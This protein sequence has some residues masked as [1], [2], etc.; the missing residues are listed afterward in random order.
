MKYIRTDASLRT[1]EQKRDKF[2]N[3]PVWFLRLN[4]GE[5]ARDQGVDCASNA[6]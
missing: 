4:E 2:N 5:F 1:Q 6:R 3:N